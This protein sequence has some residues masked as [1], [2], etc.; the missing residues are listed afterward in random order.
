MAPLA[1][2]WDGIDRADPVE[3]Q[4]A[5]YPWIFRAQ[6][7][8]LHKSPGIILP[9]AARVEVAPAVPLEGAGGMSLD[10]VAL[11]LTYQL[12]QDGL[13]L[14]VHAAEHPCFLQVHLHL[15]VQLERDAELLL[16]HFLLGLSF[17]SWTM[18]PWSAISPS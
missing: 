13:R 17:S 11:N 7:R 15:G 18:E 2:P 9:R 6:G 8:S 16:R 3:A 1:S 14:I 4:T 10:L 12:A 5:I